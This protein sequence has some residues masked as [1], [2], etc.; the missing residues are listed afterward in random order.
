MASI[1]PYSNGANQPEYDLIVAKQTRLMKVSVKGSQDGGWALTQSLLKGADYHGAVQKWL[2][3]HGALTAFC[4]VQFKGVTLNE[5]PRIYLASPG[6]IAQRLRET[7]KG[8]GDTILYESHTWGP[9]AI[10]FGTAEQIPDAWRFSG[11]RV[12]ELFATL[13]NP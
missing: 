2:E 6:Q 12:D 1:S 13:E 9:R 10:G 11:A 5:L 7:R 8:Q 4:L 3:R